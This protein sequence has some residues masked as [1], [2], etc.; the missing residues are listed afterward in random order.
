M[1]GMFHCDRS[2]AGKGS[3]PTVVSVIWSCKRE[4]ASILGLAANEDAL[5][6]VD[7]RRGRLDD[8]VNVGRA[9]PLP[10]PAAR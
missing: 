6:E 1:P 10:S 3:P 9:S 7:D 2:S 4:A 5:V 8:P